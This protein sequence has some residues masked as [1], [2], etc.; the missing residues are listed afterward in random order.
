MKVLNVL[1]M[2]A[3]IAA[4]V[5]CGGTTATTSSSSQAD[6]VGAQRAASG[7]FVSD[8]SG[9]AGHWVACSNS[10]NWAACPLS[11]VVKSRLA[12]LTS[13]G[14]FSDGAGCGEEYISHTQNGLNGAPRVLSAVA[15]ENGSV[16]VVIQRAPSLP[17]LTAVMTM[18]NRAWLAT[19]L[20]SGTGPS[21]SI[22]SAKPN[23]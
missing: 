17:T 22:L 1:F 3:S 12:A 16:A 11:V 19:D 7:L 15:A 13:Q 10:D 21:A 18:E 14:Y 20:A 9:P 4:L 6:V 2:S 5:G 8:P 23:C